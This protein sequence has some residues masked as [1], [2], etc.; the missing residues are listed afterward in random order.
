[1]T[2]YLDRNLVYIE[3]RLI[4][5]NQFLISQGFCLFRFT[6]MEHCCFRA[7]EI[8]VQLNVTHFVTMWA[9]IS[10]LITAL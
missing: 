10:W 1:M 3:L 8:L 4:I 6:V 9:L 5:F 7:G 2:H